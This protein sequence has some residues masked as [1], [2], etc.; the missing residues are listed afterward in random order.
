M[1]NHAFMH[2]ADGQEC[3][4]KVMSSDLAAYCSSLLSVF[5][6]A[7]AALLGQLTRSAARGRHQGLTH[8]AAA[9]TCPQPLF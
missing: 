9:P 7:E 6:V 2:L 5:W 1:D 4:Q 3:R 8:Q